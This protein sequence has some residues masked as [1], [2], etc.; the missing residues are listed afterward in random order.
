MLVL[1]VFSLALV[2]YFLFVLYVLPFG[3]AI[4]I[5]CHCMLEVCSPHSDYDFTGVTVERML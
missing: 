3:M 5:L 1:L 2:Q 4:Y